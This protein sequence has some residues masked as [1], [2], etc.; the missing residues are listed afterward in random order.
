M[1]VL[2]HDRNEM[3]KLSYYGILYSTN[4]TILYYIILIIL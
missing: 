1:T 4:H 2:K 3:N